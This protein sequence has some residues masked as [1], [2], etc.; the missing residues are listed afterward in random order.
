MNERAEVSVSAV[1]GHQTRRGLVQIK[2]RD[3]EYLMPPAKAREIAT[4]L[5]EAAGAAEAD[6]ALM[7]VLQRSQVDERQAARMLMALR[8]ERSKIDERARHEARRAFI[9]DQSDPDRVN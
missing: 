4:F 7:T 9:E 6:E 2:L 5:L 8:H 1:F 3:V